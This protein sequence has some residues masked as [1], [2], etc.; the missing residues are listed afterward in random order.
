[1][2]ILTFEQIEKA[3]AEIRSTDVKGKSY[4]EVPQRV[5]A[6]RKCFPSGSI[7]T[8]IVSLENGVVI[9]KATV[10]TE[11]GRILA[12]GTASEKENSTFINKTSFIENCETSAVGRALGFL[13]FGIDTSIASAE[14]VANDVNHQEQPQANEEINALISQVEKFQTIEELKSFW[15][16]NEKYQK[17]VDLKNTVINKKNELKNGKV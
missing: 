4:A 10:L 6:F 13:G 12:T 1:M 17:N 9:M 16:S 15:L 8:E 5:K 11:N 2:E 7:T 14:E 3:N